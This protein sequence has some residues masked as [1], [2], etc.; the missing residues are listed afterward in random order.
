MPTPDLSKEPRN[1]DS[2]MYKFTPD[3]PLDPFTEYYVH[4]TPTTHKIHTISARG[5]IADGQTSK[6]RDIIMEMI[7]QKYGAP[8]KVDDNFMP[9]DDDIQSYHQ[10]NKLIIVNTKNFSDPEIN[11]MYIDESLNELADSEMKEIN[12][13]NA[14]KRDNSGL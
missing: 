12:K 8:P 6:H 3:S 13:K 9:L 10:A 7:H 14:T 11:I 4:L 5:E 2:L 1:D